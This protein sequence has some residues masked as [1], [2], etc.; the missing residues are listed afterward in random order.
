MAQDFY[1]IC[2]EF[3]E[4]F[5]EIS[6][7]AFYRE[8]FPKGE[9]QK[10]FETK[11]WKYNAIACEICK[12]AKG[13]KTKRYTVGDEFEHLDELF[14]S[15]NFVVMAPL[16]YVGKARTA[17]NARYLFALTFDLDGIKG[18]QGLTDLFFQMQNDVL[19]YPTYTVNSGTGLHL[20]YFF[21]FPVPLFPS[22][23]E[24]LEKL[25]NRLTR[26]I[27]NR[28]V[29]KLYEEKNVQYEPIW[30]AFR[31]VG[32]VTKDFA[33]TG[34][35]VRAWRTGKPTSLETLN[36]YVPD[37]YKMPKN[38]I[39]YKPTMKLEEAKAKFPDWY[40]RRILKKE[41]KRYW[42]VK[43]ALYD[44]WLRK[45]STETNVGHRYYC[46]MCL[47]IY[48]KKCGVA[49]DKLKEDAMNLLKKFDE[50]ST[51]DDNR[52]TRQDIKDGL[53]AYRDEFCTMPINS[54]VH[55]SGIPIQKNKRN[56]RKRA[57]HIKVMNKM[58]EIKIEL[59]E[60]PKNWAGRKSVREEVI[61]YFKDA[62]WNDRKPSY[63]DFCERTGLKKSVYYKYKK[64][65]EEEVMPNLYHDS[66]E[67]SW[68]L[69]KAIKNSL[70]NFQPN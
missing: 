46:I 2:T 10:R 52:F 56:G 32:G 54:I 58:R 64:D 8:L 66:C 9:L 13:Y 39:Q 26:Q 5:D 4:N 21:E 59:G 6:A 35:R 24:P 12:T 61:E 68:I 40:D 44:W 37:E 42:T 31:I 19:P 20:Y 23:T 34:R 45:I 60:C 49:F 38:A 47:A 28:Y 15:E 57:A 16:S 33:K 14:Q 36:R 18:K 70:K 55:F 65:W 27:W 51:E 50:M 22:V 3:F 53:K 63:K 29:T 48:A 67:G 1:E 62:D 43:P 30:Q 41:G 7:A 11:N 17:K 69:E 25:K